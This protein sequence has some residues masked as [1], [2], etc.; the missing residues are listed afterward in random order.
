MGFFGNKHSRKELAD[1]QRD[2]ENVDK[3]ERARAKAEKRRPAETEEYHRAN[4]RVA[5][6]EKSVPSSKWF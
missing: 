5:R 6:A 3:E 2:L 1:A 4:A